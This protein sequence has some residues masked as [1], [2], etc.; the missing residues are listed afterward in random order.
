VGWL[1]VGPFL[2]KLEGGRLR[3]AWQKSWSAA[4]GLALC[5]PPDAP[6]LRRRFIWYALGG[7]LASLVWAALALGLSIALP[8]ALSAPSRVLGAALGLSGGLSGLL[9]VLTLVLTHLGGFY[10]DGGRALNL[11]RDTVAGQLDFNGW[12]APS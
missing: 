9:F 11:W 3:L 2:W 1:A 10:S 12:G 4:G 7:P 5:V 6:D 8:P